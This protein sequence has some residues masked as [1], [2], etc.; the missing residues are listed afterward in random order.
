DTEIMQA[1]RPGLATIP[2]SLLL[3]ISS[4]YARRGALWTAY[5]KNFGKDDSPILVWQASTREMNPSI[6]E[7]INQH[8]LD[9]EESAPRAEYCAEFRRYI[10]SFVQREAVEAAIIKGRIELPP[11]KHVNYRAFV[12]PSGGSNDSMTLAIAHAGLDAKV[13]LDVVREV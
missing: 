2:N 6:D 5:S 13:I 10:E 8:A 1:V 7:S 4:L 12:D 3:C 11:A 9:E